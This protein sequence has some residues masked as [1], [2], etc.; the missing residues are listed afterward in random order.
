MLQEPPSLP[1]SPE[2]FVA[3]SSSSV[4]VTQPCISPNQPHALSCNQPGPTVHSRHA[5]QDSNPTVI[6]SP[7]GDKDDPVPENSMINGPNYAQEGFLRTSNFFT[8]DPMDQTVRANIIGGAG[9]NLPVDLQFDLQSLPNLEASIT[10][11]ETASSTTTFPSRMGRGRGK[12]KCLQVASISHRR[13]LSDSYSTLFGSLG[14][15]SLDRT[16]ST[17]S[18]VRRNSSG[19]ATLLPKPGPHTSGATDGSGA[20][21]NGKPIPKKPRGKRTGPLRDG[22]REL[23][24]KR[25]NERTVCIGCKMAKVMVSLELIRVLGLSWCLGSC[26]SSLPTSTYSL[27][28]VYH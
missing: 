15:Q 26:L 21:I 23:A 13:R 7:S 18:S 6:I 27:Y 24:T 20:S 11:S 1:R 12:S 19:Q 22:R 16:L 28:R 17:G 5:S 8:Y 3:N 14:S 9:F 10:S 2:L 25:R 4:P